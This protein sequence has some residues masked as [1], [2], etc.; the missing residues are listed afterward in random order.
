[1]KSQRLILVLKSI[2]KRGVIQSCFRAWLSSAKICL[3]GGFTAELVILK[4]SHWW[5]GRWKRCHWL[6]IERC[7]WLLLVWRW[8]LEHGRCITWLHRIRWHRGRGRWRC[9]RSGSRRILDTC[10]SIDSNGILTFGHYTW[11]ILNLARLAN[12]TLEFLAWVR[13]SHCGG[14]DHAT[15]IVPTALAVC[16]TMTVF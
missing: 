10:W 8:L 14:A 16:I 11:N 3:W 7:L 12:W 5:H 1:M 9:C 13:I 6:W 4:C 2:Y 15:A